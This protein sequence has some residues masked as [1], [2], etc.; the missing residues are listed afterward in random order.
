MRNNIHPTAIIDYGAEIGKDTNVWHW[1]HICSGAKIGKKCSFGQNVFISN[2]VKIGDNVKVQNNVSIY[3]G[4]EIEDDVF[5]GPSMVFTN[6]TNPR[7]FIVRKDEFKKTLLK[8]FNDIKA[9]NLI[10]ALHFDR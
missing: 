2:E 1:V 6:V 4:V 3:E 10:T 5:L 8:K 9:I 7:S